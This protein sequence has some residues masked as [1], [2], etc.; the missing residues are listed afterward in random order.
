MQSVREFVVTGMIICTSG[1]RT[2]ESNLAL[3][4]VD[5]FNKCLKRYNDIYFKSYSWFVVCQ[6]D[7][8]KAL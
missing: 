2:K 8:I 7:N 5:A 3:S 4:N 1:K 6:F